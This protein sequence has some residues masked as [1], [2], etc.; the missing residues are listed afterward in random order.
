MTSN[1]GATWKSERLPKGVTRTTSVSCPTASDCWATGAHT[2]IASTDGGLSWARQAIESGRT[3]FFGVDC[4]TN[5]TCFAVGDT[6]SRSKPPTYSGLVVATSNAGVSW[7]TQSL[8]RDV[9]DL[10]SVSCATQSYCQAVGT[11]QPVGIENS[12]APTALS[13]STGGASWHAEQLP[14]GLQAISGIACPVATQCWAIGTTPG[15]IDILS[16]FAAP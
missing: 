1:G 5:S 14:A 16:T 6:A 11:E 9:S 12:G 13:T 3:T 2:I 15:D 8:P 7:T 10:D 4:P